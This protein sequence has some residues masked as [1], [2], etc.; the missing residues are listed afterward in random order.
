M[1]RP[2]K[3]HF[4]RKLRQYHG[5]LAKVKRAIDSR[6][7]LTWRPRQRTQIFQRLRELFQTLSRQFSGRRLSRNLAGLG[8]IFSLGAAGQTF[9][10]GN[11]SFVGPNANP[12]GL[13]G[14]SN[15]LNF[16]GAVDI[17]ADGDLD[18][19]AAV[20]GGAIDFFENIG[21]PTTASFAALVVNPFGLQ[22]SNGIGFP[23]LCDLDGDTDLDLLIGEE[24]LQRWFSKQ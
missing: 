13:S 8:L 23:T 18:V 12:Y 10:Q 19:F 14:S 11:I 16:P 3:P 2:N 4:S 6:K 5:L 20:E 22:S 7:I 9:A 24:S 21:T 1:K 15:D 17:D